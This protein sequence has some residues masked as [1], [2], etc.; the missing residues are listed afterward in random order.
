MEGENRLFQ[1]LEFFKR[2]IV[3]RPV[4]IIDCPEVIMRLG[5]LA[6]NGA[7]EVDIYG[8]V[9]SSH[10]MAGDVISGVGG[11]GDFAMNSYLS[12]MLLPSIAHKGN[13][14]S[15][16]PMVVHVDI[17]EQGVDIII[18]EQGLADLRGLAPAERAE[19]IITRCAH[20]SYRPLLLHYFEQA[21][22]EGGGH[23]PHLLRDAFS[24][25]ER[26]LET[27]TMKS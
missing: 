12:V 11:A 19:K 6:L 15:I 5:I 24:F 17:P 7:I 8:H 2:H 27:G 9:N 4:E 21:V 26:F 1:N 22:R 18:T 23:E 25:H 20:P 13:I 16:V 10:I 14:S 3:L